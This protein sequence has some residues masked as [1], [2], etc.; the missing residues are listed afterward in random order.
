MI[1]EPL[2]TMKASDLVFTSKLF[3]L[4]VRILIKHFGIKKAKHFLMRFGKELGIEKA[5]E[6][7]ALHND[8]DILMLEVPKAHIMLGHVSKIH[9]FGQITM[10]T[11]NIYFLTHSAIGKIRLRLTFI[12]SFLVKQR[13]APAIR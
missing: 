7:L 13:N 12:L 9:Y 10:K 1:N 6:L 3:L 11:I 2:I 8:L 5:K 4:L